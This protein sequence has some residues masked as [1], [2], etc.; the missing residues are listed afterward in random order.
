[1]SL[2]EKTILP[3]QTLYRGVLFR[4]RLEARWAVFYDTLG[5]EW[6]YE[7]E[8]FVI[9]GQP[10]LPDFWLPGV[11]DGGCHIEIKPVDPTQE[12]TEKCAGLA[13]ASGKMVYLFLGGIPQ[14]PLDGTWPFGNEGRCA[15][16]HF[17]DGGEDFPYYWCQCPSCNKA[18]IQYG[19][20]A[21][22][23]RCG[24]S[25][26]DR[27]RGHNPCSPGLRRAYSAAASARFGGQE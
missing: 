14:L 5:V 8:G 13:L 4:S 1:M 11:G 20:R 19:G 12:E 7:H 17:S 21:E 16:A 18:G 23:I 6:H 25:P 27:D 10:Y 24:C 3:I 2:A 15:H 22:R 9:D 26:A